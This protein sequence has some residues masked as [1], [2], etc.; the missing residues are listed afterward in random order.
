L[1]AS[2]LAIL[3]GWRKH[4]EEGD[5]PA[6]W[7]VPTNLAEALYDILRILHVGDAD[8]EEI[9]GPENWERY[10]AS[11]GLR[12]IKPVDEPGRAYEFAKATFDPGPLERFGLGPVSIVMFPGFWEALEERENGRFFAAGPLLFDQKD[13]AVY[14]MTGDI[15]ARDFFLEGCSRAYTVTGEQRTY[16]W[17]K[18]KEAKN[19]L[20]EV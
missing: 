16:A 6:L 12:D 9:M 2:E 10:L 4:L 14:T 19:D 13:K 7:D 20:G 17:E 18:M 5:A 15:E 1:N 3:K 8:I 11:V